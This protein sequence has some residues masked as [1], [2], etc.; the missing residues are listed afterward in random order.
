MQCEVN[1]P[2]PSR[3]DRVFVI[4][5]S[6]GAIEATRDILARLPSEFP[7]PILVVIHTAPDSPGLLATVLQRSTRLLVQNALDGKQLRPGHVYVA[8][9]G[10]HLVVEDGSVR[11][12]AG[13][14]ENGHRPAIDPLFRSAAREYGTRAVGVIL[15]GYLDDGCSGMYRIK[16]A[17]GVTIAQ[18]PDEAMIPD[19]PRNAIEFAGPGYVSR[20]PEIAALMEKLAAEPSPVG[21]SSEVLTMAERREDSQGKLAVYTCPECHGN[22]WEVEEGNILKFKCRVGHAFTADTMLADQGVDVERALWA[23]LRVM[24]EHGELST[25]LA[26]RARKNGLSYAE[27]LYSERAEEATSNASVLRELLVN[28]RQE[29]RPARPLDLAEKEADSQESKSA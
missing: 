11:V 9:P 18:D 22:L 29:P 27:K 5:G 25:R 1:V 13:P 15:S 2:G 28:G 26:A 10:K 20:I 17:G 16:E 3:F 24:E 14:V 6:A 4:G 8:P 21:A 23:A 7:S 12:I 19:M